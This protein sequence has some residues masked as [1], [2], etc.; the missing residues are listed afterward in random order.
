MTLALALLAVVALPPGLPGQ[1]IKLHRSIVDL[2]SAAYRDSNDAAAQY[3]LGIG[4]WA[5]KRYDDAERVLRLSVTIEPRFAPA[6]LALGVLPFARRPKLR[7]EERKGKVPEEWKAALI[8]SRRL[9][10][11]A[12]LIDPLVDLWILSAVDPEPQF[13]LI[14]VHGK[15]YVFSN[16]FA[17]LHEDRYDD[18][19][20]FFDRSLRLVQDSTSRDSVSSSLLWYHGLC[21]AHLN[22]P[23]VAIEDFQTLLDRALARER[24]DSLLTGPL[25]T[26]DFRYILALMYQRQFDWLNAVRLYREALVNDLGLYM[27]HVEL[28]RVFAL[29]GMGDS[30]VVESREAVMTNPEDPTLLFEHGVTLLDAGYAVAAEDT[31]RRSMQGNPRDSRV[32][33]YLGVALEQLNR[34]T[35]ARESYERFLTLAPSRLADK[36][37][38][39]KRR[40]ASLQ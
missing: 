25:V 3:A 21:A 14:M 26:N 37:A 19:F 24:S 39:A 13:R 40:L 32:A 12:F 4:Y 31:L 10:R 23:A 5:K 11:R 33:Y 2:E 18:A 7:E 8:E 9:T 22:R 15:V 30:A 36:I 29:R 1:G 27:A 28:S 35:E 6:W 20:A 17:A 16:P 34:P 38:E